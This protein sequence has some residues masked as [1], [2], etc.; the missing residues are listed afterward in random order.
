MGWLWRG[1]FVFFK[2]LGASIGELEIRAVHLVSIC[3]QS[4]GLTNTAIHRA[5]QRAF[6]MPAIHLDHFLVTPMRCRNVVQ[7]WK[8]KKKKKVCPCTC[9][10]YIISLT[11][12]WTAKIVG[13]NKTRHD[14]FLIYKANLNFYPK[15]RRDEVK[16]LEDSAQCWLLWPLDGLGLN[17]TCSC[18]IKKQNIF[19]STL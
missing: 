12:S 3:N 10:L 9:I 16:T 7:A 15:V 14:Q 17:N 4:G 2:I 5:M 8:K 1:S 13:H 11:I 18:W 19:F 6:S